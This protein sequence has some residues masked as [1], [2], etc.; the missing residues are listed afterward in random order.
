MPTCKDK[1]VSRSPAK[2]VAVVVLM[3][4]LLASACTRTIYVP[5]EHETVRSDTVRLVSLRSDTVQM[6]DSVF[7]LL[8]GDTTLIKEYH[9]IYRT[10]TVHDT[11]YQAKADTVR[12]SEPSK[13]LA[14]SVAKDSGEIKS[15]AL[16]AVFLF[17][18]LIIA[19]I[20]ILIFFL[21]KKK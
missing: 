15:F 20:A 21:K 5:T 17:A 19:G 9:Y 12:I 7:V 3:I 16:L 18:I 2:F 8:K 13:A 1:D 10:E 14:K 4:L 6:S 11:V